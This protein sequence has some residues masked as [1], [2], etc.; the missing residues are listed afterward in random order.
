MDLLDVK[1]YPTIG[2]LGINTLRVNKNKKDS[3]IKTNSFVILYIILPLPRSL[4]KEKCH[5]ED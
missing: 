1:L 3:S 4:S 2:L 5:W